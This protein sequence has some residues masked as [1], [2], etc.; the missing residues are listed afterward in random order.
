MACI[1]QCREPWSTVQREPWLEAR[2]I[3][4][5]SS[6]KVFLS[7]FLDNFWIEILTDAPIPPYHVTH[8]CHTFYFTP[9]IFFQLYWFFSVW[10]RVLTSVVGCSAE[11][12]QRGTSILE[13]RRKENAH[14]FRVHWHLTLYICMHVTWFY[15]FSLL[16]VKRRVTSSREK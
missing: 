4:L 13:I 7:L 10:K 8:S 14:E 1:Q 3:D 11:C 9:F 2:R 12:F 5:D 15:L 16:L 6:D